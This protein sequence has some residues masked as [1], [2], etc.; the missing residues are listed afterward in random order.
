MRFI[1]IVLIG[2]VLWTPSIDLIAQETP[3]DDPPP[4]ML[5]DMSLSELRAELLRA[6]ERAEAAAERAAKS[7]EE[8]EEAID[9]ADFLLELSFNL[10]G[11]F[12]AMSLI[13]T[14][15]GGAAAVFG[16]TRFMR[17]QND[18]NA[19]R[20]MVLNQFA[21]T[22]EQFNAEVEQSERALR[23]ATQESRAQFDQ[24]RRELVEQADRQRETTAQALLAQALLPIGERQYRTSDYQGALNTYQ[25]ALE[26]DPNNPIVH[27]R[28]GYVYTQSKDLESAEHHYL[29][30]IML[31]EDFAPAMAG[32]GFVYRR[33]AET[34]P[35]G[36]ERD[37][38]FNESE[39]LL[40][41]ALELSPKLVDDD[42]E[43]WWGVLGG[44]YKRRGQLDQAI[45]AYQKV[46][47]VTP[48]S[49]YG[50]GNLAMLYREKGDH[51]RML[52]IYER[53]EKL[54]EAEARADI[55]NYWGH[56]DL[57]VSRYAL[58]K[59][60]EAEDV[61]PITMAISSPD[62]P[63]MLP[64]LS[65]TLRDLMPLLEADKHPPIERAIER[66][67]AFIAQREED[68]QAQEDAQQTDT[69]GV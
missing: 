35:E 3:Q 12:E 48:N 31:E 9:R 32:L 44:L 13:V 53:V 16:V 11:L 54:A 22:R 25:R 49:S 68:R 21:E 23:E 45:S 1:F 67:E 43:S 40:L 50:F 62:S 42:G 17:A 63:Y 4:T 60:R 47:E 59:W 55:D 8:A 69:D 5:E 37:K 41:S 19:V 29:Q 15:I 65:E 34:L 6:I 2:F 27:Q 30:S 46:T 64:S 58:G 36:I 33:I 66:I 61:L 10:L 7:E 24:L 18:L 26:L 14:V 28:L 52:S 56:A 57:V 38:K 20:E 51:E 39:R